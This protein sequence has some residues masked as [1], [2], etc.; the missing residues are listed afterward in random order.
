MWQIWSL[1]CI[2][3]SNG[4]AE[5]NNKMTTERP[6]L[7]GIVLSSGNIEIILAVC[8]HNRNQTVLLTWVQLAL[9]VK[10]D[11]Y[12]DLDPLPFDL[13]YIYLFV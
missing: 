7:S 3:S 6:Q 2:L 9:I 8:L 11:S 13:K 4:P 1:A 12:I 5:Y 10:L